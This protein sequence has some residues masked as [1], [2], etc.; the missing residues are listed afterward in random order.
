MET[1]KPQF[2]VLNQLLVYLVTSADEKISNILTQIRALRG[3]VTL[4]VYE[5]THSLNASQHLTKIR[6]KFLSLSKNLRMNLKL[7]KIAMKQIPG[8]DSLAIKVR[9][10]DVRNTNSRPKVWGQS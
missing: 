8:I 9:T 7:F 3:V 5:A 2:I 1:T 10:S 4:S 6:V